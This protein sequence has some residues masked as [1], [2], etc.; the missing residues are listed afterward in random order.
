MF[1]FSTFQVKNLCE[2]SFKKNQISVS[3]IE[4]KYSLIYTD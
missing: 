1:L 4:K 2:K 3:E